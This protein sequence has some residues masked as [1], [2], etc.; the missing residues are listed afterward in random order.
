ML[1]RSHISY[2]PDLAKKR[3]VA[4]FDLLGIKSL[5]KT[6]NHLSIFVLLASAIEESKNQINRVKSIGNVDYVDYVWF[7]DTFIIYTDDDSKESFQVIDSILRWFIYFLIIKGD[8][9]PVRGAIS[10]DEFYIDRENNLFFGGALIEAYEYGEAQDWI[11]FLLC[12]S[13]D[14]RLKDLDVPPVKTFRDYV[15]TDIPIKK[16]LSNLNNNLPALIIGRWMKINNQNP[17]IE[18]L[19][20]MKE[21][22]T[23]ENIRSKYD[24]TIE[25]IKNP[26]KLTTNKQG[27]SIKL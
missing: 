19:S 25:F 13:A 5:F 26:Q 16:D 4:Y 14:K 3:W 6:K 27:E 7:S 18:K 11:G 12:P 15:Y 24:R 9:I 10:C 17:I 1:L 8:G 21:R 23:D 2:N 22:I 20:K